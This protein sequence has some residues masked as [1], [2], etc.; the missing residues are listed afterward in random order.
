MALLEAATALID[1]IREHGT[2]ESWKLLAGEIDNKDAD[3]PK[4]LLA[5]AVDMFGQIATD[6]LERAARF[7][8]EALEL[9]HAENMPRDTVER[10]VDRVY[11][12]PR[13]DVA[14]EIGQAAATL[15]CLAVNIG[16]SSDAE[17][18]QEFA[19]V[20]SISKEEW[21][22]RHN[23]KVKLN[24]ANCSFSLALT[25]PSQP[26]DWPA[27]YKEQ[28]WSSYPRR[29]GKDAAMRKLEMIKKSGKVPFA[30]IL[31]SVYIYRH[32]TQ[33][34]EMAYIAH[35]ATWLHRGSWNDDPGAIKGHAGD[36]R[37]QIR[38]GFLGRIVDQNR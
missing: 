6:R 11:S 18:S 23:A 25:L 1:E 29:V 3:R 17:C 35:P 36:G 15:E 4:E 33:G 16:L 21:T 38:N 19:R 5:W 37:G 9:V 31:D 8:E 20:Q 10:I 12:R 32:E 14:K 30:K 34:T 2:H 27:D 7:I 22:K 13:G 26:K 28:F 24:I